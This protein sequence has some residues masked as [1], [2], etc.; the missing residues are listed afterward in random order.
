MIGSRMRRAASGLLVPSP[1]STY[2][3]AVLAQGPVRYW[4]MEETAGSVVADEVDGA[5]DLTVFGA[6]LNVDGAPGTGS[7]ASFDGV[8]DYMQASTSGLGF[9]PGNPFTFLAWFNLA[10]SAATAQISGFGNASHDNQFD[11]YFSVSDS[12]IYGRTQRTNDHKMSRTSA[13]SSGSWYMIAVRY[14]GGTTDPIELVLNGVE[15]SETASNNTQSTAWTSDEPTP[16]GVRSRAGSRDQY[17][18][19]RIDDVDW[20]D[21][22]L[23]A[24]TIADLYTLGSS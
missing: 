1:P 4:R 18:N 8:D 11:C 19:G 22:Y 14:F 13:I 2:H 9:G 6:D 12:K 20:F 7:A 24:A 5:N 10:S 21:K 16:V 23:S 17:W 3:E 15:D